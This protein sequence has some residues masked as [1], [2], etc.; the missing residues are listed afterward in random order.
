[1]CVFMLFL[2]VIWPKTNGMDHYIMPFL[3]H[4]LSP[5]T[6]KTLF[7]FIFRFIAIIVCTR[8]YMTIVRNKN[9]AINLFASVHLNCGSTESNKRYI[10]KSDDTRI[11]SFMIRLVIWHVA[12]VLFYDCNFIYPLYCARC[13]AHKTFCHSI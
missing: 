3:W 9:T 5:G 13:S 11:F 1:M 4:T 10:P 12:S 2:I 8:E 7:I 6:N